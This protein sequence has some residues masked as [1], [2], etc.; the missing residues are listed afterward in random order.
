MLIGLTDWLKKCF[1]GKPDQGK[2][3]SHP[4][5]GQEARAV[6]LPAPVGSSSRCQLSVVI[7][8]KA[9]EPVA[10]CSVTLFLEVWDEKECW[11]TKRSLALA[12]FYIVQAQFSKAKG[13]PAFGMWLNYNGVKPV[14]F[15]ASGPGHL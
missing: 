5:V 8:V 3:L 4:R 2:P 9:A 14:C 10:G 13:W 11:V 12:H 1:E 7:L 15:A 6:P